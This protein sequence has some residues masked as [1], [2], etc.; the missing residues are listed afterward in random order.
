MIESSQIQKNP[1][2]IKNAIMKSLPRYMYDYLCDLIDRDES[3][4]TSKVEIGKGA[5]PAQF[6][7]KCGAPAIG[8]FCYE[9]GQRL[10][11]EITSWKF[12]VDRIEELINEDV[13][14]RAKD[15]GKMETKV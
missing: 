2:R 14:R 3:L 13:E 4:E 12:R 6:C 7:P 9:C 10:L 5:R 11:N 1:E 15:E 8:D